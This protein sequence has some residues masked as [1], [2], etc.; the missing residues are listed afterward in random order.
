M[1]LRKAMKM[2]VGKDPASD[3]TTKL[4]TRKHF[5]VNASK[6]G[7]EILEFDL[8]EGKLVE[9]KRDPVGRRVEAKRN[10]KVFVGWNEGT[11]GSYGVAVPEGTQGTITQC[12][13]N[14][15]YVVEFDNG[16]KSNKYLRNG[17]IK[18]ID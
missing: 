9:V 12:C 17:D 8:S 14:S 5:A 2:Y 13:Y 10:I 18:F 16:Y 1:Q 6:A 15:C 3:A 7:W 4:Y 11:N